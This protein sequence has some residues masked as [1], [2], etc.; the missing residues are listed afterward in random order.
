VIAVV[1]EM[2]DKLLVGNPDIPVTVITNTEKTDFLNQPL[3]ESIYG[4]DAK[5]FI[6]TYTGNVGPHRGVDTAIR[7]MEKLRDLDIVLYIVGGARP[8]MTETMMQM[9]DD[10]GLHNSVRILGY[11]PFEKF[12]SYMKMASVNLIPH[13]KN[14]HT[15]NTVPHKLFQSMMVGNPVLVSSVDP[16]K[17][18]VGS[19]ESGLVFKAEDEED[20]AIQVRR[21]YEDRDICNKLGHNGYLATV[22]GEYNWE[23]TGSQLVEMYKDGK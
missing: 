4:E 3:D 21:L 15:D 13:N 14:G 12:F 19:C 8:Y 16:L 2:K 1:D 11:Q 9:V 6:I 23:V 10:L 5:R 17:R 20:F 18:I 22:Q 7:G